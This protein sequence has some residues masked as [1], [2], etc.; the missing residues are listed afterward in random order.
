MKMMKT[1][2]IA[3]SIVTVAAFGCK[4]QTEEI[5]QTDTSST[6]TQIAEGQEVPGTGGPGDINPVTAQTWVDDVTLGNELGADGAIVAGKQGDDF[7][8][9]QPIHLAMT[10]N[11]APANASVKVVWFAPGESKI[12]EESKSVTAGQKFMNFSAKDTAKWA[13]GD[14]RVEVWVADEKVNQQIFQMVDKSDAA[15]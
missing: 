7:V 10:V 1:W 8:P 5:A 6:D 14:Y 12:A 11:D 9:G 2:L 3:L 4:Q 15:T 13:K